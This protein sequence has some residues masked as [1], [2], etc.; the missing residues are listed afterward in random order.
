MV[1]DR[2]F[3]WEGAWMQMLLWN[4]YACVVRV[5]RTIYYNTLDAGEVHGYRNCEIMG[6]WVL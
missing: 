5:R 1:L 4:L 2:L 6:R 3:L